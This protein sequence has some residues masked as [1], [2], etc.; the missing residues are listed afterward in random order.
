MSSQHL[1]DLKERDVAHNLVPVSVATQN[2]NGINE[3][4]VSFKWP[5]HSYGEFSEPVNVELF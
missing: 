1:N 2:V 3:K 4:C 5:V